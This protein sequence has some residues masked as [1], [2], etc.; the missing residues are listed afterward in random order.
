V[1]ALE[2]TKTGAEAVCLQVVEVSE[3]WQLLQQPT[4]QRRRKRRRGLFDIAA[5]CCVQ[6]DWATGARGCVRALQRQRTT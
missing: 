1:A 4:D 5:A 2:A 6:V 3:G